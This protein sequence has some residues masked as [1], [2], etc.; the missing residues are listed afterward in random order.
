MTWLK[1]LRRPTDGK[2]LQPKPQPHAHVTIDRRQIDR[3]PV[4]AGGPEVVAHIEIVEKVVYVEESVESGEK[5]VVHGC[6]AVLQ[7]Q[8]GSA[9][10]GKA[11]IFLLHKVVIRKAFGEDVV[12]KSYSHRMS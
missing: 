3:N 8:V 2:V 11:Q 5:P 12:E 10:I 9:V 6:C 7:T 1:N 4:H